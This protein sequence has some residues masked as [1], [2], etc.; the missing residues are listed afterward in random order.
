MNV[1]E[2]MKLQQGNLVRCEAD[3]GDPAYI[4][5]VTFAG[6]RVYTNI[7]GVEYTWITVRRQ[8]VKGQTATWP[9]NRIERY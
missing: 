6:G 8:D 5:R 1:N 9:S 4:G 3:R 2:A 7:Y